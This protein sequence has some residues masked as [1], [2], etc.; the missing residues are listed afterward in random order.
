MGGRQPG[1]VSHLTLPEGKILN[2]TFFVSKNG[3]YGPV[4]VTQT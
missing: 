2:A 3:I 1:K 4:Y